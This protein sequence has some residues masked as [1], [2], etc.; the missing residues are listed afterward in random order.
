MNQV[1]YRKYRPQQ[2]KDFK[3]QS[4]VVQTLANEI[5]LG[6]IAHAYLFCGHRGTGKTSMARLFAKAINSLDRKKQRHI[7][8]LLSL[9]QTPVLHRKGQ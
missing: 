6:K 8:R 7:S 9:M 3:A 1:L 5:E 4:H 2:F